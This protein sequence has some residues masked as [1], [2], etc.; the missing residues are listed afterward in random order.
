MVLNTTD[1]GAYPL[2]LAREI[3]CATMEE[4]CELLEKLGAVCHAELEDCP[5]LDLSGERAREH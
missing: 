2:G 1:E 5:S 3:V 4:R